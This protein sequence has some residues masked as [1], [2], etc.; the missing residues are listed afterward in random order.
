MENQTRGGLRLVGTMLDAA[1]E[2][3]P[4]AATSD[5]TTGSSMPE[6]VSGIAPRRLRDTFATFDLLKNPKLRP[7]VDRCVAVSKGEAWCALLY[8]PPGTGKTHLAVAAMHEYGLM[9]AYFWKVPELLDWLRNM[10]YGNE[11]RWDLEKLTYPYRRHEFLL[12]LDD[13]G[14]ENG[15]DWAHEQLYRILDSRY[16]YELPT[17]ITTNQPRKNLDAR[18]LSRFDEGLV[19]CDGTDIRR[20][21]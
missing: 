20:A 3:A 17:I 11:A 21:R 6:R 18:L 14:T 19:I 16:E 12:V 2:A 8:G 13:L 5:S 15:T 1:R 9:K 7:A 10:A 4:V